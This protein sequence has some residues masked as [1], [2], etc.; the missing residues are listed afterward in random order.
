M[1]E[2]LRPGGIF[3]FE[4]YSHDHPKYSKFGPKNPDYIVKPN[5]LLEIFQSLRILYY[6]DTVAELDEGMHKGKAAL[7][8]FIARKPESD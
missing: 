3:I 8:R 4:T 1:I 7:I 6:E 5:E 2:S